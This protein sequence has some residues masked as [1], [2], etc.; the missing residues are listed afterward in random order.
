[1]TGKSMAG[2]IFSNM[3]EKSVAALTKDRSCGSIPFGGRYRLIDFVISNMVAADITNV[4]VITKSNYRSLMDHIGSGRSWDL[5]RKRGGLTLLPPYADAAAGIYHGRLEAL[6]AAKNFLTYCDCDWIVISDCDYV[7]SIDLRRMLDDHISR[8]ADI[9]CLVT[10]TILTKSLQNDSV[11][12]EEG[13]GGRAES[14]IINPSRTGSCLCGMNLFI[15]SRT[16]LLKIIAETEGTGLYHFEKHILQAR[17][18]ELHINLYRSPAPSL[19]IG[20]VS[21][22]FAAS[23]SLLSHDTRRLLFDPHPVYTKVRDEMPVRYGLNAAVK[24]SLVADGCLVEGEVDSSVLFRSVD[25]GKGAVVK[26]CI[27]MQGCRVE[28]GAVIEGV[29]ADKNTSIS[30][31]RRLS[32]CAECPVFI[33]KGETV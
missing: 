24:N 17:C 26:N 7:C 8:G 28:D 9:S 23:M 30:A 21:G 19:R 2:L 31:G 6:V 10:D 14:V 16:L 20:S 3:H 15:L 11:I 27:L 33:P 5:S 29:I 1:M 13:A 22:Y 12:Y 25:I 4:G 18:R 32:G